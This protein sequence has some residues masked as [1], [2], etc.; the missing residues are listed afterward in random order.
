MTEKTK[1]VILQAH[2]YGDNK[3]ILNTFSEKFGRMSFSVVISQNKNRTSVLPYCQPLFQNEIEY[4]GG[5]SE[6]K[7]VK[8][9]SPAF[10]YV[11]IPKSPAKMS[12]VM[13]LSE[14]LLKTLTYSEGNSD[15]YGFLSTSL[16][17]LDEESFNGRNFHLKF[18]MQLSK[19]I[20]FYPYNRF[21]KEDPCFDISK[22]KFCQDVRGSLH[23]I[24]PPYSEIFSKILDSDILMCEDIPLNGSER[25]F[26]L[27]KILDYYRYNFENFREIRSLDILQTVFHD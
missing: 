16:Q 14:C 7:K 10:N 25:S 12:V 20:G 19:Y 6:I 27:E 1:A 23:F 11:S 17:L 15:L 18:L 8:S 2:K 13:F 21:S 5:N 9:I 4:T 26:L 24:R 3:L 22:S